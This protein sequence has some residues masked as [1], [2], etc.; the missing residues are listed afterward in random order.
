M[1]DKASF[2]EYVKPKYIIVSVGENNIY[3]LPSEEV[4]KRLK[5]QGIVYITY[6]VK[7]ITFI[8]VNNKLKIITYNM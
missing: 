3:N 6:K 2:L 4:I 5:K 7:N 1:N 8:N